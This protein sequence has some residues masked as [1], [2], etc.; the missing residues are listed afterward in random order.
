MASGAHFG[1]NH[2]LMNSNFLPFAY[3][4]RAGITIIDMDKALPLLRRAIN[5]TRAIAERGGSVVFVGTTPQLQRVVSKAA[6]RM[7]KNGYH[8]GQRWLAG[9][10][11]N[12]VQFYGPDKAQ[13]TQIVPDLV[14]IL[15]PLKNM[16]L[17]RECSLSHVPT[18]ALI[19]SNVDPRI[20]TY[21]IPANDDST[22]TA[23]II[24][25]VLSIAAREGIKKY[26]AREVNDTATTE[27][28]SSEKEQ[29][30][31]ATQSPPAY[32]DV[33]TRKP[34]HVHHSV[35]Q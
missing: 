30:Q 33:D 18:I 3:G 34:H 5:V 29:V 22:R 6:S 23:E 8:V 10:L 13:R 21:P 1:H 16:H 12:R 11:T 19:D 26:I 35:K 17:L 32:R 31:R 14:I 24:A 25:G 20:V 9:T 15:N 27:D 4:E 7:P 2:T 28:E